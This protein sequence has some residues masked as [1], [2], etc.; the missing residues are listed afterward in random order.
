VRSV[1]SECLDWTLIW[2]QQQLHRVLTEY[3]HHYNRARPHRSLDLRPP[4]PAR[5]VALVKPP[6]T[7]MSAIERIDVLGGLIHE[8]RHAA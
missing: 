4:N 3:L 2:H 5:R 8:Y 7:A 1:R 6:P